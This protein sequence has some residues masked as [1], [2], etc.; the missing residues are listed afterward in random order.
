MET[1]KVFE[2]EDCQ[3]VQLPHSI[4]LNVDEVVAQRLGDAVLLTPKDSVWQ[5][6]LDGLNGFTSDVFEYGREQGKP[7]ERESL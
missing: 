2:S 4:R 3:T 1:A 7:D 6:F 5:T